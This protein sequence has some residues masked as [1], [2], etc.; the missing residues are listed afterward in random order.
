MATFEDFIKDFD[1]V[2]GDRINA[3]KA[4]ISKKDG[5]ENCIGDILFSFKNCALVICEDILGRKH[6]FC[7]SKPD[8]KFSYTPNKS[9]KSQG[10]LVISGKNAD[11]KFQLTLTDFS[12][13]INN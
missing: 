1:L 4:L 13:P 7:Y 2:D 9:N 8:C 11:G 12:K 5:K 3:K 6:E 10:V